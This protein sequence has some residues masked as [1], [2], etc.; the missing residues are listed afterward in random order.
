M[1]GANRDR[2]RRLKSGF[3]F[4]KLALALVAFVVLAVL[5][6]HVVAGSEPTSDC[7]AKGIDSN[8]RKEGTCEADGSKLVVVNK[9]SVLRLKTLAARL[10]G[11]RVRKTISGPN[12]SKTTKG[13]FVTFDLAI[14]NLTDAPAAVA[15]GQ[16]WL[17]FGGAQAE[18]LEV[19]EDFEPRS[20]LARDRPIPPG[21]TEAGTV[22]FGVTTKG[23]A[24]LTDSGNLDLVNLGSPIS[25]YEPEGLFSAPEF[26]VFRTYQ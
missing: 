19:D 2:R 21:G 16:F 7:K 10:T 13:K 26:G 20:F 4:T 8:A 18:A 6:E 14:T 24:H 22:T 9:D 5:A 17:N 3:T 15:V 25:I 12:G 23:A 11:M 1:F